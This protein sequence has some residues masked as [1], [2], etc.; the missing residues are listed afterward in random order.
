[1]R[2]IILIL[3]FIISSCEKYL[4]DDY[5]II[6][7]KKTNKTDKYSYKKSSY[8]VNKGDNY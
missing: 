1:M 2:Y 5:K 8:I 6:D 3:I 4:Y 7:V